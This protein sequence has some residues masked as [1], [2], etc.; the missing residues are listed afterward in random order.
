MHKQVYELTL[1]DLEKYLA[2]YF[3][4]IEEGE[5]DEATVKPAN[6]AIISGQEY[7]LVVKADFTDSLGNEFMGFFYHGESEL[8]LFQPCMYLG[9]KAI[10][11]WFG[12]VEPNVQELEDLSFPI[13]AESLEVF[14][15][16]EQRIE[17]P[18][19]GYLNKDFEENLVS[20]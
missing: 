17:I 14:G 3:P 7:M 8:S 1:D 13:Y 5:L 20:N 2:W 11:F 19:Y 15:L 6:E 4:M 12:I 9:E 18:G 10:N 16:K